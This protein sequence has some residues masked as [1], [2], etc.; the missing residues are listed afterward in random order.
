MKK[1]ALRRQTPMERD[2]ENTKAENPLSKQSSA[3]TW[4]QT[5]TSKPQSSAPAWLQKVTSH[6]PSSQFH[7]ET[8]A[9]VE[10]RVA[11]LEQQMNKERQQFDRAV[12]QLNK[13]RAT[14]IEKLRM[15]LEIVKAVLSLENRRIEDSAD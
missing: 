4:L 6:P 8:R 5:L 15:E 13:V 10:Q 2:K 1:T 11:L 12:E 9:H 14:R 7:D 3:P